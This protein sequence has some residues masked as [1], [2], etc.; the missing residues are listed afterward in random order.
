[1]LIAMPP[2]R[3]R[4][5]FAVLSVGLCFP[6]AG[7]TSVVSLLSTEQAFWGAT[8]AQRPDGRF[9]LAWAEGLSTDG[10]TQA[11]IRRFDAV[12]I[13]DPRPEGFGARD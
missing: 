10:T 4:L 8:I 11:R 9:T 7:S 3:R 5:L 1:M 6:S 12:P 2:R 13:M